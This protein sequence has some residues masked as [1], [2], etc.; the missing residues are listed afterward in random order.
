MTSDK[1]RNIT[2]AVRNVR[3]LFGDISLLLGT[4][5]A[6]VDGL[7]WK[8]YISPCVADRG[9]SLSTHD[10]WMPYYIFRYYYHDECP[11]WLCF[12]CVF[13][14]DVFHPHNTDVPLVGAGLVEFADKSDRDSNYHKWDATAAHW[15]KTIDRNY[16]EFAQIE[17]EL[18]VAHESKARAI[19]LL[20]YPL[21]D[22]DGKLALEA[23]I[24]RPLTEKLKALCVPS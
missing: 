23:K 9:E 11:S 17:K 19:S 10:R 14:D 2:I 12:T 3:Q 5:E 8:P 4:V 20:S 16:G 6:A 22:I 13:I 18:L 1:S 7:S 15:I 21:V 24:I